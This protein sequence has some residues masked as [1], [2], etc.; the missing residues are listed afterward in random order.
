MQ[1]RVYTYSRINFKLHCQEYKYATTE[2]VNYLEIEKNIKSR[3]EQR[4]TAD[5]YEAMVELLVFHCLLPLGEYQEALKF[6]N[7]NMRIREWKKQGFIYYAKELQANVL[8]ILS[9]KH[10]QSTCA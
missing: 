7:D 5:Q 1:S 2:I 8:I 9:P 3:R 4:L 6:L 10:C